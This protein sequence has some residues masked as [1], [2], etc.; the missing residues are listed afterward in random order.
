MSLFLCPCLCPLCLCRGAHCIY[1][2][3]PRPPVS[4]IGVEPVPQ[5]SPLSRLLSGVSFQP[6]PLS[7]LL[8]AVSS[9]PSPLS[10]LLSAVSSQP[11]PFSRLLSAVSSQASHPSPCS[12]LHAGVSSQASPFSRRVL[13]GVSFQPCLGVIY[14]KTMFTRDIKVNCLSEQH[15]EK[16]VY[17]TLGALHMGGIKVG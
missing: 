10:R 16:T 6:S 2:S 11:S 4:S 1:V 13:S 9:Q 8:S 7:R 17:E 15:L 14:E 5:A 3:D 12:R